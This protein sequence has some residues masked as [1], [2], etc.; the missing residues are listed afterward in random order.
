MTCEDSGNAWKYTYKSYK[1][2][3]LRLGITPPSGI[4]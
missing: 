4:L 2:I 1:T 3:N